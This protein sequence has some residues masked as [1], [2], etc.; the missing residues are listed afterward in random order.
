MTARDL[1]QQRYT[2]PNGDTAWRPS[3]LVTA[4]IEGKLLILDGIH[5]VNFGTLSVLSRCCSR[6][7]H[8]IIYLRTELLNFMLSLSVKLKLNVP[9]FY[10]QIAPWK[11]VRFIW[12]DQTAEVGQVPDVERAAE[13]YWSAI[14][15]EVH[16]HTHV[17]CSIVMGTLHWLHS[18]TVIS[19]A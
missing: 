3:P 15:G 1:L 18:F 13:A 8:L 19:L 17:C 4:S 2:L 5:R 10:S 16:T 11:G 9:R 6:L 12:W 7:S 14:E